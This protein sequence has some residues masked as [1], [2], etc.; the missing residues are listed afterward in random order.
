METK[1]VKISVSKRDISKVIV[2]PRITE[3]A[4]YEAENNSYAFEIAT[5]ANKDQVKKAVKE[6][7]KVTPV[8]IAVAYLPSKK[9]VKSGV[10]KAYVFLKKGDKIEFI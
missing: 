7:Y 8:K 2:R 9:G 4:A 3:K 10:K 1:S 5:W 6:I